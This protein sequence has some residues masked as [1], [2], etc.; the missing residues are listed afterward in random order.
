MNTQRTLFMEDKF[1][2]RL[3]REPNGT[4]R[5]K[6]K[7]EGYERVLG[8]VN[9]DQ[10][11][12]NRNSEKHTHYKTKS[13]GFNYYLITKSKSFQYIMLCE[14]EK[15]YYKIP[16]ATILQYGKVLH[17]KNTDGSSFEV[18]IFLAKA[19]IN[20]YRITQN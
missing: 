7:S 8:I 15:N 16:V 4:I 19:I 6:L 3:I 20:N 10:L 2:N 12:V 14:D 17:F 1:G 11:N 5:L 18:Q 9:G 13:Y